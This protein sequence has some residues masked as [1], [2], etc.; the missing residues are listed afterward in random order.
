MKPKE[1]SRLALVSK[2]T[3]QLFTNKSLA[4]HKN[5]KML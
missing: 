4:N 3:T 1:T 5:Q 2:T